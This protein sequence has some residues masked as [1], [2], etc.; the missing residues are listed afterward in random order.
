MCVLLLRSGLSTILTRVRRQSVRFQVNSRKW[1]TCLTSMGIS[2]WKCCVP[3][4]ESVVQLAAKEPPCRY[5]LKTMLTKF[6]ELRDFLRFVRTDYKFSLNCNQ[7]TAGVESP[8]QPP[9]Q[10][11]S[12]S[13]IQNPLGRE[14]VATLLLTR[15]QFSLLCVTSGLTAVKRKNMK[16][17]FKIRFLLWDLKD[18]K[19]FV[20]LWV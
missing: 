17:T 8:H 19:I 7:C 1:T 9:S 12:G 6:S 4:I 14:A 10:G 20:S 16:S 5:T 2:I 18:Y 11:L 13:E 3:F 15:P